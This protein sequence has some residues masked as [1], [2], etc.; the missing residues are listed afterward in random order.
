MKVQKYNFYF[1]HEFHFLFS[2]TMTLNGGK[3]D[4]KNEPMYEFLAEANKQSESFT[5]FYFKLVAS[6]KSVAVSIL[7]LKL[8][9]FGFFVG[10]HKYRNTSYQMA[11]AIPSYQVSIVGF[12]FKIRV[13]FNCTVCHFRIPWDDQ[14]PRA[15][16][17][18]ALFCMYV[19]TIYLIINAAFVT[20]FVGICKNC[21]AFSNQFQYLV[22]NL[23]PASAKKSLRELIQ[24]HQSAKE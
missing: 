17:G 1:L 16:I 4:K 18:I 8:I 14:T 12:L 10:M 23:N 20:L 19:S 9:I 13:C 3:K 2:Q 15:K 21:Q 6:I 24:Y 11:Y 5:I 7:L 22:G